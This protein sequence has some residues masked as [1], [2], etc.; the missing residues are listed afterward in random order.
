MAEKSF[1]AKK[2]KLD[3]SGTPTIQSPGSLNLNAVTVGISTNLTV[4][5]S[6]KTPVVITLCRFLSGI[7][8][9]PS[10]LTRG[11]GGREKGPIFVN[12]NFIK[13]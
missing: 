5:G 11:F 3:G 9:S 6:G 1:G 10:V 12:A 4:G 2:I 8:K 7:G 13:E